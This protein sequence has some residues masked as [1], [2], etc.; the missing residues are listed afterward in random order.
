VKL[1][2]K[3]KLTITTYWFSLNREK[4]NFV[5]LSNLAE[6]LLFPIASTLL[7]IPLT[8]GRSSEESSRMDECTGG[9][10]AC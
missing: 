8:V 10:L 2:L 4:L 9:N 3:L 5:L 6:L 7:I 1:T